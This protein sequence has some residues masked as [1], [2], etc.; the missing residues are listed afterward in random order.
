MHREPQAPGGKNPASA[1][2]LPRGGRAS[3]GDGY[4]ADHGHR[5]GIEADETAIVLDKIP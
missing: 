4:K 1:T 3:A 5:G 2:V